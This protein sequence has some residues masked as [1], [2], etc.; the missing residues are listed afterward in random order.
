[1]G[2]IYRDS[3]LMF[4]S[5]KLEDTGMVW[6]I[7]VRFPT[8]AGNFPLRRHVHTGSGAH[9]ASYPLSI[10]GFS[11]GVKRPEREA[12]HSPPSSAEVKECM[13]L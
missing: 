13:E 4:E 8:E 3:S 9:P 5:G 12:N 2:N 10:G 11:P 7:G 1:V 6:M